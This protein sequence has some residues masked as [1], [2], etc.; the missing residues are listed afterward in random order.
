MTVFEEILA[1]TKNGNGGTDQTPFQGD[2]A[3][4]LS[5]AT[6]ISK[7]PLEQWKALSTAA[8][9]WYNLCVRSINGSQLL[10][11]PEGF[12]SIHGN[13]PSDAADVATAGLTVNSSASGRIQSSKPNQANTPKTKT[14][15]ALPPVKKVEQIGEL[16]GT[17]EKRS[18]NS[19]ILNAIRKAVI[20]HPD[21]TTKQIHQSLVEN[22][23]PDT[24]LDIVAVNA[25]DIRR[26][27]AVV[28][29]LGFWYEKTGEPIVAGP[30]A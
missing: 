26:T 23:F 15:T 13:A 21:W 7:C 19:G 5:L 27:I 30:S 2:Q 17:A 14:D 24:K 29:E 9:D 11:L 22:G 3:Y 10:P 1:T 18:K 28:K 8:S 12:V 4:I 20:L 6:C 25:G 16:K